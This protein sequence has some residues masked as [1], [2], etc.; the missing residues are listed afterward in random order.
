V[1]SV[2]AAQVSAMLVVLRLET[3]TLAG[4]AGGVVSAQAAVLAARSA[5]GDLLPAASYASTPS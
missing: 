2:D 3:V 4:A 1:L 5:R